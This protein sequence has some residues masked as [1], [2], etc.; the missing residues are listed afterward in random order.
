MSIV[1]AIFVLVVFAF[2][3]S[4][5]AAG[6]GDLT[7]FSAVVDFFAQIWDFIF[8]TIPK[9]IDDFFIF[10]VAYSLYLKF[11]FIGAAVSFSHAVA[12]E[13]LSMINISGVVNS[14]ISS[15]PADLRQVALDIR[16]FDSL[17]VIIEAAIT[18]FVY[19]STQ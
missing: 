19:Q 7:F 14:A 8:V 1:K 5:F 17:T 10:L 4:A 12:L 13:F 15:L 2:S 11:V 16:F 9:L 6:E 3:S 18:R